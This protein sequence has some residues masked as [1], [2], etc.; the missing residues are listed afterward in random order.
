LQRQYLG[1]A[2]VALHR[3]LDGPKPPVQSL[4]L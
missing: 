4:Q 3:V 2:Q 1:L